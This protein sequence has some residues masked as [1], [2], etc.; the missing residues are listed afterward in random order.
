M[1]VLRPLVRLVGVLWLLALA[2]VGLGVA[3]YCFDGLVS[4][5]SARPDRLVDL[6]SVRRSSPGSRCCA[7]SSR[8]SSAACWRSGS[9]VTRA[10][11][12]CCSS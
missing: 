9:C 2:L 5:G 11:G 3:L 7:A 4:L 10:S 8:S 6:M 1:I 12:W